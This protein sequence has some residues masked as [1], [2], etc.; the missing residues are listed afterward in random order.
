[1]YLTLMKSSIKHEEHPNDNLIE[2]FY[3]KH[4][5]E[6]PKYQYEGNGTFVK[7]EDSLANIDPLV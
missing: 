3:R 1:M 5:L 2:H 4:H 6:F 7:G